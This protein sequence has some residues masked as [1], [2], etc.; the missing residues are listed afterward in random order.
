MFRSSNNQP[1]DAHKERLAANENATKLEIA[2]RENATKERIAASENATKERI[3]KMIADQ[4]EL[5]GGTGGRGGKSPRDGGLGGPGEASRLTFEEAVFYH[6]MKGGTGGEGGEG[7]IRGGGG[8]V[9]HGQRFDKLL[10]PGVKG[11]VPHT[12][13]AKFCQDYQLDETLQNLLKSAGFNTVA[14]LLKVTDTDLREARFKSG[15]IAELQAALEDWV[16]EN[17]K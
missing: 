3:A 10:V 15:H 8:G 12:K 9:G 4:K 13:M 14:A 2:S 16:A 1:Y 7:G 11:T 6:R 5:A 17:V